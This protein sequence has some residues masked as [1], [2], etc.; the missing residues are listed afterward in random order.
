ML[1]VL[2]EIVELQAQVVELGN[3]L[4]VALKLVVEKKRSVKV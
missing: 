3:S 4:Q 1:V 2:V